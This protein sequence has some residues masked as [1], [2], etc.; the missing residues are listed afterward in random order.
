MRT[1]HVK[2][3]SIE[4]EEFCCRKENIIAVVAKHV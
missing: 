4:L 3:K 2:A 1:S